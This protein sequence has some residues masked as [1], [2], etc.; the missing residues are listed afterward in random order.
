VFYIKNKRSGKFAT[1]KLTKELKV[2]QLTVSIDKAKSFKTEEEACSFLRSE[3]A[4]Y[5]YPIDQ[6]LVVV[7]VVE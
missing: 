3:S 5:I 1:G 4:K 7:E 2:M 6:G